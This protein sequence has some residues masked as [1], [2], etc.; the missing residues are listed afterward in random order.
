MLALSSSHNIP[1]Q[2]SVASQFPELMVEDP[3]VVD[4]YRATSAY[5]NQLAAV[6]DE[7]SQ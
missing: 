6:M 1:I 5:E 2:Q 7:L 3:L 4:F